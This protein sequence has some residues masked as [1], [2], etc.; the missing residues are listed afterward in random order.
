M[1]IVRLNYRVSRDSC[2]FW[3]SPFL[4]HMLTQQAVLLVNGHGGGFDFLKKNFEIFYLVRVRAR[5]K[6]SLV[7]RLSPVCSKFKFIFSVGTQLFGLKTT[8]HGKSDLKNSYL[9]SDLPCEVVFRPK[10][11]YPWITWT[12]TCWKQGW[13]WKPA[14]ACTWPWPWQNK[15]IQNFFSKNQIR[16]NAKSPC[17]R[18]AC[19][20]NVCPKKGVSHLWH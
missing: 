8:S 7:N 3:D 16:H 2:I 11:E 18:T 17:E 12:W 15:K 4:G 14:W 5:Y 1:E 13:A 19:C 20:V 10:S 6:L 9:M